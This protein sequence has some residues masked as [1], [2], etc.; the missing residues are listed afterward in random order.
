MVRTLMPDLRLK[1]QR[2]ANEAVREAEDHEG[3][4]GRRE[5]LQA[6][7]AALRAI[8]AIERIE[9]LERLR[10]LEGTISALADR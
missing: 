4:V 6:A 10:S 5:W 3:P 1:L 7:D 9:G 8:E 2:L